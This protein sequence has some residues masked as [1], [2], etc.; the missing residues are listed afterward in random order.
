MKHGLSGQEFFGNFGEKGGRKAL[1]WLIHRKTALL[2]TLH[3]DKAH[4]F[5]SELKVELFSSDFEVAE[6]T[7]ELFHLF[8]VEAFDVLLQKS[9]QE[10]LLMYSRTELKPDPSVP[11]NRVLT[12]LGMRFNHSCLTNHRVV[13]NAE[14]QMDTLPLSYGKRRNE[15][16]TEM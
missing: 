4:R 7:H 8:G 5:G 11:P 3:A 12:S 6:T 2:T 14:A 1:E 10:I 16:K 15:Q 13:R 9:Q